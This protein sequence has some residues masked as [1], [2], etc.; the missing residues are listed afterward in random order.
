VPSVSTGGSNVS[1]WLLVTG[2]VVVVGWMLYRKKTRT[3]LSNS[4]DSSKAKGN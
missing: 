4:R 3:R 1:L 2:V